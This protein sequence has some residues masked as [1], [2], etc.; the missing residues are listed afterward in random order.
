MKKKEMNKTNSPLD[1]RDDFE[2]VYGIIATH[3]NRVTAGINNESLM[4]VWE[5]GGFVSGKLKSSAWGDGVVRMLADYIHTRNPKVR[6]WSY[7]TLYKMVQLYDL[8]TSPAFV[9]M[10]NHYGMQQYLSTPALGN[11][12]NEF[13]PNGLA[14]MVSTEI[15]PFETAQNQSSEIVPFEMAQIPSVLFSTGWTNH[16]IIMNRCRS[17]EERLFYMLY[18][19][20]EKLQNKELIRA[21]STNTMTSVLGS[22]N[23]MAQSMSKNY[24][25]APFLFKDRVYLDMLGLPLE[26]K[27]S[28]LRKE[29]VS[30]MKD[31]ILELGK[32]FL[33]IDEEHRVTVGSKTFKVDLLFYHRLLQ[34]MVAIELKTTEFHPKDLGQ[35]EFYLEALDQEERRSNENPSIGILLCKEADMEV[36]RFAL[37]RSMSPTM[38]A[39]YKE[40]LQVG[41]VIQQSLVEF[42]RFINDNK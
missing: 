33:F 30:H 24:P 32:D 7:R 26:Y 9:E 11:E 28:K 21:I 38:V 4:M 35:L 34:C 22:G 41:S 3:R 10:V 18:A 39:L 6:G 12:Q 16:Q 40:Q 23:A 5:V 19:G 17:N 8:Y 13:V 31:F 1:Y 25:S 29:I 36:V 37:S 14:Q 2:A 15:V 27:E 20:R 42:C